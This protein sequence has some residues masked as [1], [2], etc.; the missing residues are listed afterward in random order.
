MVKQVPVKIK[1]L[2]PDAV[3]PR[4]ARELDAGFDLVAIEDA[5]IRP[6]ETVMVRTGLAMA[7]PPGYELQ[8]RPRSGISKDTKLRISNAPGTVDAGYKNEICVLIDNIA[9]PI[10]S[11][12]KNS[13]IMFEATFKLI[14]IDGK[15][16]DYVPEGMKDESFYKQTYI[17]R[18]GERIAQGVLSE[19][20]RAIFKELNELDGYDRGGGFGSTGT[21]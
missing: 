14:G 1:R 2:H 3:I 9:H 10:P 17:I 6:G 15:P 12:V 18:K 16:T 4:Y 19:V 7:L 11:Q 20:P 5:I 8:I 21:R 13:E